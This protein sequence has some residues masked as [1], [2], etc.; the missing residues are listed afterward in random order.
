MDLAPLLP[1]LSGTPRDFEP[2]AYSAGAVA[3]VQELLNKINPDKKQAIGS[4]LKVYHDFC[5]QEGIADEHRFPIS[6]TRLRCFISFFLGK[7]QSATVQKHVGNL[8]EFSAVAGYPWLVDE[9]LLKPFYDALAFNEKPKRPPRP[10]FLHKHAKALYEWAHS[11]DPAFQ[12][13]FNLVNLLATLMGFCGTL[14]SGEFTYSTLSPT[15]LQQKKRIKLSGVRRFSDSNSLVLSLPWTKTTK[16]EG[17]VVTLVDFGLPIM[18]LYLR[19]VT[20]NNLSASDPLFSYVAGKGKNRGKRMFLGKKNWETWLD[21]ALKEIGLKKMNGHSMRIGAATQ[22]LLNGM[23]PKDVMTAG[24]WATESAFKKYWRLIE[25]RVELAKKD[26]TESVDL[27]EL[28]EFCFSDEVRS[29]GFSLSRSRALPHTSCCSQSA[30]E[31]E[32][33]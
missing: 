12:D 25:F 13:P 1:D 15:V 33:D 8:R 14:R 21:R 6:T 29:G 28:E 32:G 20:V 30:S 23:D 31:G 27:P 24:R 2:H 3:L 18:D 7:V 11:K 19:H 16:W 26:M 5:S 17:A 10:P 9:G 22:M 4:A